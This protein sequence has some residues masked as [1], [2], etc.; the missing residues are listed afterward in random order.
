[1]KNYSLRMREIHKK[2]VNRERAFGR[3]KEREGNGSQ[4]TV[5]GAGPQ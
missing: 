4:L 5:L 3:L 2:G 1:M